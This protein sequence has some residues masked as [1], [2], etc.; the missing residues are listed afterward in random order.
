MKNKVIGM[1]FLL[2]ALVTMAILWFHPNELNLVS[3]ILLCGIMI[4]A[5]LVGVGI[6]TIGG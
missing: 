4:V 1:I 2:I 3:K 6:L 5:N